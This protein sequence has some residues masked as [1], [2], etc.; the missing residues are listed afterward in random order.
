MM[1]IE[2]LELGPMGNCTYL[3]SQGQDALLI[4]PVGT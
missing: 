4:D 1:N 3:L 2:V